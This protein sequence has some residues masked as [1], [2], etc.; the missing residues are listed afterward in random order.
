MFPLLRVI[1]TEGGVVEFP[2]KVSEEI[3]LNCH[4]EE[5][6]RPKDQVDSSPY[7]LRMTLFGRSN[8]H[9]ARVQFIR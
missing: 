9:F 8:S 3:L 4:P 2:S 1:K 5:A 6:E 7:G